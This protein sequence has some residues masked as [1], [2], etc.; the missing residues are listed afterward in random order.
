MDS[1]QPDF[2]YVPSRGWFHPI[3]DF[4]TIKWA[5]EFLRRYS[6]G[7]RTRCINE[8]LDNYEDALEKLEAYEL[9]EYMRSQVTQKQRE[10]RKQSQAL[11]AAKDEL[12]RAR[13]RD[14]F[15]KR[16]KEKNFLAK[17][18]GEVCLN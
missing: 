2:V 13:M 1:Q 11:T 8:F 10:K 17:M 7:F 5:Y 14:E 18:R 6:K 12:Y 16:E 15:A 3:K 4:E 9:L